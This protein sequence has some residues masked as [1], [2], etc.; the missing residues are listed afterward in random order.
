MPALTGKLIVIILIKINIS[1]LSASTMNAIMETMT[2]LVGKK[3]NMNRIIT[4]I[5]AIV[6]NKLFLTPN[7]SI[8]D[9]YKQANIQIGTKATLF[10]VF[11]ILRLKPLLINSY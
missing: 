11:R 3:N 5:E 9:V 6:K 1:V 4:I 2:I 7:F 10:I 8:E